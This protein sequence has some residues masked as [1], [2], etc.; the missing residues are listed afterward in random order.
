MVTHSSEEKQSSLQTMPHPQKYEEMHKQENVAEVNVLRRCR[1]GISMKSKMKN[2]LKV[3][4]IL[5]LSCAAWGLSM[6]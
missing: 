2:T 3:A 4:H 6:W 5:S 1:F